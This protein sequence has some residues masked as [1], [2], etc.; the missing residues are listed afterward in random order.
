MTPTEQSYQPSLNITPVSDKP[1]GVLSYEDKAKLFF[2]P[3]I[4][5][6]EYIEHEDNH[7][8]ENKRI[9]GG[10]RIQQNN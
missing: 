4:S 9:N 7:I 10:N 5:N 2:S 3:Q 1:S 8:F 6:R